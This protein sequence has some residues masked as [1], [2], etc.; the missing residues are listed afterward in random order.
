M[1]TD[2][3][4]VSL[5]DIFSA[6]QAYVALSRTRREEG[7]AIQN[8]NENSIYCN[9]KIK[10]NLSAMPM[11]IDQTNNNYR[12]DV[13]F[14]VTLIN[15]QKLRV[16]YKDLEN[17]TRLH[18]SVILMTET[19]VTQNGITT[20]FPMPDCSIR[21]GKIPILQDKNYTT[22]SATVKEDALDILLNVTHKNAILTGNVMI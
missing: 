12:H 9:D 11:F 6:G 1:T 7:L 15:I 10:D 17:D 16:H 21:R 18:S 19:W 5:S 2:K 20:N 8:F 4:V 14:S 3:I 22:I 13:A